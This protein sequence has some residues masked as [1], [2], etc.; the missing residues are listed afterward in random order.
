MKVSMCVCGGGVGGVGQ[1]R[2]VSET[3]KGQINSKR[4][5]H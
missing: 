4:D 3:W 5:R 2:E 1:W